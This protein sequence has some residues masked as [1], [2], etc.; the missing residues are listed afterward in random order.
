MAVAGVRGRSR[1]SFAPPTTP[2]HWLH[3]GPDLVLGLAH[4]Q[5]APRDELIY[6]VSLRTTDGIQP[7]LTLKLLEEQSSCL[8][9][10]C[11]ELGVTSLKGSSLE[12][13]LLSACP[14]LPNIRF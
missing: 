10:P 14:E 1:A 13:T 4:G 3:S 11:P 8:W 6:D 12:T 2:A 7:S 5:Q 9:G